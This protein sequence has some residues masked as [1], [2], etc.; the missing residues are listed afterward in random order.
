MILN[1][2]MIEKL[3]L[4]IGKDENLASAA[5]KIFKWDFANKK[6]TK[7]IDTCGIK[8]ISALRSVD[9]G[10]GEVDNGQ[11]DKSEILGPSGA[12]AIYKLSALDKVK[13]EY[14]YFDE[15]MFM[16]KEDCD[17]AY[18][19][20]SNGY[21]SKLVPNAIVYHDRTAGAIGKSDIKTAINRKNKSKQVKEW[22]FL[23]QHI[24]FIKHW[25]T[26]NLKRK[27]EV[28]YFAF[29]MFIFALLYEQYLLKQYV[30]IRHHCFLERKR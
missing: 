24:I 15:R 25:K 9:I 29:K 2:D 17:L 6:K 1:H 3:I 13:D 30:A 12:A 22:S 5:P 4:A 18:R 21:K 23:N 19:L 26:L 14:G 8:E 10:Q 11:Y 28:I 27:I 16:Y 7:I 20:W